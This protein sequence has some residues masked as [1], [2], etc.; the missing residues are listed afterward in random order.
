MPGLLRESAEPTLSTPVL[1]G[2]CF[3][4]FVNRQC[5]NSGNICSAT[6]EAGAKR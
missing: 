6:V 4:R 3:H 1:S 5:P 2:R